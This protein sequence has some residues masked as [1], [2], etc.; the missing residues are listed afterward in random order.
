MPGLYHSRSAWRF[1]L[2][3]SIYVRRDLGGQGLGRALLGELIARCE[4]GPWR[5][6]LAVIGNSS[7]QGSI[8]LHRALGFERVGLLPTV[9]FKQGRWLDC[10]LMQR[11]LGDGAARDPDT[12]ATVPR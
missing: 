7:N 11:P 4:S 9:G 2:E 3:D 12:G 6:M 5:Q 8:G 10:V 1:T